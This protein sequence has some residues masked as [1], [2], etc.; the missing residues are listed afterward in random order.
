MV[1]I[2]WSMIKFASLLSSKIY[3][4]KETWTGQHELQYTNYALR[5]LPKGLKFFHPLSPSESPKVIGL[6]IIHHPNAFNHFNGVTH[7]LWCGKEE[8]NEGP[9]INY[10]WLTHYKLGLVCK[11]CFCCPLVTSVAIWCHD[12]K[13][14][15]PSAEP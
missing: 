11:K 7:C 14:C 15:Q 2:F 4:I 8:Q 10:L 5:T 13:S 12:C 9:V 1:D 6:T 3:K